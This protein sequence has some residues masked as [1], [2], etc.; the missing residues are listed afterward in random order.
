MY[1]GHLVLGEDL[2]SLWAAMSTIGI[3][4]VQDQHAPLKWGRAST[5]IWWASSVLLGSTW[6][7]VINCNEFS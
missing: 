1:L 5:S 4:R 2:I 7:L 6:T 3:E